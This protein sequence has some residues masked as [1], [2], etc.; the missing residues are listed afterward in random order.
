[1]ARTFLNENQSHGRIQ[2]ILSEKM[3]QFCWILSEHFYYHIEFVFS[4]FKHSIENPITMAKRRATIVLI[5]TVLHWMMWDVWFG[6]CKTN[7]RRNDRRDHNRLHFSY[8]DDPIVCHN[9]FAF[10]IFC[11]TNKHPS[12]NY[13][14]TCLFSF[15][16]M[17]T[18]EAKIGIW[19][20]SSTHWEKLSN[21]WK[22]LLFF[23]LYFQTTNAYVCY[24]FPSFMITFFPSSAEITSSKFRR[25]NAT[26]LFCCKCHSRQMQENERAFQDGTRQQKCLH[27][28]IILL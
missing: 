10:D 1:M 17:H 24:V 5:V 18:K 26:I 23:S 22:C 7:D 4:N 15:E 28:M 13:P 2:N 12:S 21:L 3:I 6:Y 25:L 20:L 11:F 14:T 16:N 8:V 27:K 9:I 19:L